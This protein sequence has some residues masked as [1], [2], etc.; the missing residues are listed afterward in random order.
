ME[1]SSAPSTRPR[2]YRRR[3]TRYLSRNI[4]A[5]REFLGY[6]D[7]IEPWSGLPV[8]ENGTKLPNS[9]MGDFLFVAVDIDTPLARKQGIPDQSFT[10]GVSTL[11]T[12]TLHAH[13]TK[14]PTTTP[15]EPVIRSY[16]FKIGACSSDE[17]AS[18]EFLFGSNEETPVSNLKQ[19]IE[20]LVHERDY[21][22]VVHGASSALNVLI[23]LDVGGSPL[24]IIDT[25]EAARRPLRTNYRYDLARLLKL[26][27]IPVPKT[28]CAGNNA[29]LILQALLIIAARDA[30][31]I[32]P[33]GAQ[34]PYP[35]H[36]RAIA[37][38]PRQLTG[39]ERYAVKLEKRKEQLSLEERG[40][41]MGI[42]KARLAIRGR[43]E[44]R[45]PT[46][47]PSPRPAKRLCTRT[48]Q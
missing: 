13:S 39:A 23:H 12:R 16:Q 24:Y 47:P 32:R 40:G 11:D 26:L 44:Y 15:S 30:D 35:R 48:L 2:A 41:F 42:I 37:Q 6:G 1:R 36:F 33:R 46:P 17:D 21:I 7:S 43:T 25:M 31:Q 45:T 4:L 5:L 22:A 27:W 38:T 28:Y 14:S 34:P 19:I 20:F 8:V 3:D 29:H 18:E 10:M 9:S